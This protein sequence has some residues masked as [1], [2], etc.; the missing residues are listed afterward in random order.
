MGRLQADLSSTTALTVKKQIK[1][2]L[3]RAMRMQSIFWPSGRIHRLTGIKVADG[4]IISCPTLIQKELAEHWGPIY[5]KKP[6]DLAAAKTLL[7]FYFRKDGELINGFR[8]CI[9]SCLI[10][11]FSAIL[12]RELKIV[13][14]GLTAYLTQLLL[15][16]SKPLVLL[17]QTHRS[18]FLLLQMSRIWRG[19]TSSVFGFPRKEN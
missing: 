6:I 13:L 14:L 10:V 18:I 8:S 5:H 15:P 2:R 1:S 4:S 19:L 16:A 9:A 3:Q 7:G 11:K 12:L 17:W